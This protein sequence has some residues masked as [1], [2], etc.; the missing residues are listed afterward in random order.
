MREPLSIA[1]FEAQWANID[2]KLDEMD[3][4]PIKEVEIV[5]ARLYTGTRMAACWAPHGLQVALP[6]APSSS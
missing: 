6:S 2:L 4:D 1:A 5:G 3:V